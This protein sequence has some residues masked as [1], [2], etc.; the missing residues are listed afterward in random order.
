MSKINCPETLAPA[1]PAIEFTKIN[2]AAVLAT[3]F[4]FAHFLINIIGDKKI[5]PPLQLFH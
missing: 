2:N 4:G 3:V 1:K 5:P